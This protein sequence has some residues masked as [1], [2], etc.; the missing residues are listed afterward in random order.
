MVLYRIILYNIPDKLVF[1]R[2]F[3]YPKKKPRSARNQSFPHSPRRRAR[4]LEQSTPSPADLP[5]VLSASINIQYTEG[6]GDDAVT[7]DIAATY[8]PD[9]SIVIDVQELEGEAVAGS[10][11]VTATTQTRAQLGG[12]AVDTTVGTSQISGVWGDGNSGAPLSGRIFMDPSTGVVVI[13][14]QSITTDVST[15]ILDGPDGCPDECHNECRDV[16]HEQCHDEC[17]QIC[18]D[19]CHEL[20]DAYG[21]CESVCEPACHDECAP[22][23]YPD[24]SPECH[25]ICVPSCHGGGNTVQ[26]QVGQQVSLSPR[27][28]PA[29]GH[30]RAPSTARET[31]SPRLDTPPRR[32]RLLPAGDLGH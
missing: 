17:H 25:P 10:T 4:A 14:S 32:A 19:E 22:V 9:G 23:C 30:L 1:K 28:P 6:V 20:C 21:Q 2:E 11:T 27:L 18:H 24:C 5:G 12:Q 13:P 15:T 26:N 31:R 16:C 8:D 29:Q 3:I 7:L